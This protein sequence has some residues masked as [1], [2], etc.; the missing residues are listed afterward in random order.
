MANKDFTRT[1][2]EGS[3]DFTQKESVMMK[4]VKDAISLNQVVLNG[5]GNGLI[6]NV[7]DYAVLAVHNEHAKE[8]KDYNVIVLLDENG[9]KYTTGSTSFMRAFSDIWDDMA[10]SGE[11]WSLKVFGRPSNN[12]SG[13]DYLTCSII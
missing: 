8:N 1:I 5:D 7:K 2:I 10:E 6:L 9:E 13:R 12:Y 4:D 3:R 11:E